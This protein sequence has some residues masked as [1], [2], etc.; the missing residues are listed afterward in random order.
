MHDDVRDEIRRAVE[1]DATVPCQVA[2]E[3]ALSARSV[4]RWL[5]GTSVRPNTA[6]AI[7]RAWSR[8]QAR[9]KAA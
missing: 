5:Q 6:T 4:E 3:A 1:A 2:A 8:L 7:L 9:C